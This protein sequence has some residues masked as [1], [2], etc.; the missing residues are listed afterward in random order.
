MPHKA[1]ETVYQSGNACFEL[2][3]SIEVNFYELNPQISKQQTVWYQLLQTSFLILEGTELM[4]KIVWQMV[5][6][7]V[8]FV[9][10]CFR[11]STQARSSVGQN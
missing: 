4:G 6:A 1:V 5:T 2:P 9:W 10:G 3:R 7:I 11:F 8:F